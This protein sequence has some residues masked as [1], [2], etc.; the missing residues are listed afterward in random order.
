MITTR[1]KAKYAAMQFLL[2]RIK[3]KRGKEKCSRFMD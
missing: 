3:R 1:D 2:D